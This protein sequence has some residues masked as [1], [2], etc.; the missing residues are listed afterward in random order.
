[1][2]SGAGHAV[3]L[4]GWDW[5]V[6]HDGLS[7]MDGRKDMLICFPRLS[8]NVWAVALLSFRLLRKGAH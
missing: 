8:P 7:E 2:Q 6:V 5:P 3:R 1:M 4:D